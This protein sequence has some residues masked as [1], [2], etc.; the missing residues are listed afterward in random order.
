MVRKLL[1]TAAVL[2]GL[3]AAPAAAQYPDIVV[4][5]GRTPPGGTV[6][7]SGR[8]CKPNEKVVVK[9]LKAAKSTALPAGGTDGALPAR[10]ASSGSTSRVADLVMGEVVAIDY[11]GPDGSFTISFKVPAHVP[12][13]KYTIKVQCGDLIQS[14][15]LE[16]LG[17]ST[18]APTDPGGDNG[19]QGG[20]LART[21]SDLNM[22]GL[23]GA[24]L[25]V[26]GGLF[27]LTSRKR[28][29]ATEE[30]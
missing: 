27:L 14:A 2:V 18:I 10:V 23:A 1:I 21:G 25:L 22:V 7:I 3:F 9:I 20:S 16:V 5:P 8:G 26:V 13:G 19:A 4:Q 17:T 15:P 24:V 11:A 6:T 30:A 28:R 12:P 29:N